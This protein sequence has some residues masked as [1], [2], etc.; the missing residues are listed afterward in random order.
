MAHLLYYGRNHYAALRNPP[1][2][3]TSQTK[4]DHVIGGPQPEVATVQREAPKA[5][6]PQQH[7]ERQSTH[8]GHVGGPEK[9]RKEASYRT[10][11]GRPET[12]RRICK[13]CGE[14]KERNDF[15]TRQ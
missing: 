14:A 1:N 9:E 13:L 6:T 12:G 7:E 8:Q 10:H 2:D 11:T 3:R 5:A 15:T 4:T